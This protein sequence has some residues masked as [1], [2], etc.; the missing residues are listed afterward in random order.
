[1]DSPGGTETAIEGPASH[2]LDPDPLSRF[3]AAKITVSEIF[4]CDVVV[5]AQEDHVGIILLG[6]DKGR[7]VSLH[8]DPPLR[9]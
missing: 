5:F 9:R 3:G 6:D 1:M 2:S 8:L 4:D 7:R